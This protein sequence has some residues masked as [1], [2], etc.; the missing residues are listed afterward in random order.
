MVRQDSN[1]NTR[2]LDNF[3]RDIYV[4][5]FFE[6]R[7]EKA[8]Y[9]ALTGGMYV[10]ETWSMTRGN[11]MK[12]KGKCFKRYLDLYL[13]ITLGIRT[14]KEYGFIQNVQFI[15]RIRLF[16]IKIGRSGLAM[17]ASQRKVNKKNFN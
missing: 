5:T 2:S 1:S 11:K 16:E 8:V 17:Y 15:L 9:C 3:K 12:L 13:I 4:K 14:K 6:I 10:C 7:E